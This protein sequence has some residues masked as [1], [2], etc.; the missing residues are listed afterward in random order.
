MSDE[1]PK[2]VSLF[3]RQPV[4]AGEVNPVVVQLF[5]SMLAEAKSG[6]IAGFVGGILRPNGTGANVWAIP[7]EKLVAG[8]GIAAMALR[9]FQDM[10]IGSPK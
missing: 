3:D 10:L 4:V 8:V 1:P 5:E 2:V 7:N 9:C 6:E